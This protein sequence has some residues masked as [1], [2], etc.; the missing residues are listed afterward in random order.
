[1]PKVMIFIDGTWLYYS[2]YNLGEQK[3][4]F[5]I[6]YGKLSQVLADQLA[7]QLGE[8]HVDLVRTHLFGSY[9]HNYDAQDEESVRRQRD[10]FQML[11]ERYHYDV[12][13]FPIDFKGRRL[14]RFDRDPED[15]FEP[16][17]KCVDIA[18][19][20][21]LMFQAALPHAFDIAIVV[22]GDQDFV[23]LLQNVRQLGKRVAVASIRACCCSEYSDPVNKASVKDFETIWLDD[24]LDDLHLSYESQQ[25][26]CES[27]LHIG[28][29][30]VWTTY[31]PRP[32]ENFYCDDCRDKYSQQRGGSNTN[33]RIPGSYPLSSNNTGGASIEKDLDGVIKTKFPD[34][35]FGF[36]NGEDGFDYFFHI[37]DLQDGL[38]FETIEDGLPV[39][40]DVTKPSR[41][42][43]AGASG[44]VRPGEYVDGYDES[45]TD[46]EAFS[47]DYINQG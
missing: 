41:N 21:S 44:N 16:K 24:I 9:A 5:N 45:F 11:Q 26:R 29:E 46:G 10:F 35:G 33:E 39:V 14:R 22:L 36:I 47:E 3:E 18:L 23:P 43:K 25:L 8:R 15:S 20:S 38:E 27:P 17:E 28:D 4:D 19:A 32:G 1:M 12:N 30:M 37:S 13:I 40:F 31:V 2:K 42:G 34:R 6:D 7:D